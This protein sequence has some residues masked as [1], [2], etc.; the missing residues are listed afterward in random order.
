MTEK[1]QKQAKYSDF[2]IP[3]EEYEK[4]FD[5]FYDQDY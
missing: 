1:E 5:T 4:S 2:P 3:T